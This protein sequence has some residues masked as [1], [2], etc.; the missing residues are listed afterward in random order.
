MDDTIQAQEYIS[1]GQALASLSKYDEALEMFRKA[2]A[3]DPML[4]DI[5]FGMGECFVMLDQF[6]EAKDAFN[7]VLLIDPGN[8]QVFFHL[9]NVAMLESS[10]E[11]GKMLYA[12]ASAAGYDDPQIYVNLATVYEEAGD[13]DNAL[14]NYTRAIARDEFRADAKTRKVELLI[15]QGKNAEAMQTADSLMETNPDLFEGYHY[16]FLL[17]LEEARMSE[18]GELIERALALFPEDNGFVF[19]KARYLSGMEK[20]DEALALLDRLLEVETEAQIGIYKEKIRILLAQEKLEDTQKLLEQ[21]LA[22]DFDPELCFY[23]CNIYYQHD[24]L[25]QALA[26]CEQL[27]GG[28]QDEVFYFSG[29][30]YKALCLKGLKQAAEAV[31]AFTAA[32]NQMRTACI[33]NPGALDLYI[34]RALCYK[35]LKD[36]DKAFEMVKYVLDVSDDVAEAYLIRSELYS[37]TGEPEKAEADKEMAASKS[38]LLSDLLMEQ[39]G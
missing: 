34:M 28:D 31:A 17:L 26:C 11:E 37:E 22:Q 39:G 10:F 16:K 4:P 32:A 38:K 29:L 14:L 19:D 20:Y 18:A 35:E 21:V 27:E 9:G 3:E 30:Y 6:A 1:Q 25:D 15:L 12:K 13:L 24:Q 23:L 8:A 5:Y 2:E 33:G 36:Y 7:K